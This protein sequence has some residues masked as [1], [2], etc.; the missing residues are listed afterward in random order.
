MDTSLPEEISALTQ[1]TEEQ[2]KRVISNLSTIKTIKD[3]EKILGPI[4][5]ELINAEVRDTVLTSS[6]KY[7]FDNIKVVF[8]FTNSYKR[9]YDFEGSRFNKVNIIGKVTAVDLD[10]TS[11]I[12]L[13]RR[14]ALG[15]VAAKDLENTYDFLV[16]IYNNLNVDMS[17]IHSS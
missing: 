13:L 3:A 12:N 17:Q 10:G 11:Q 5:N 15:Y 16:P 9:D 4:R 14:S 7:K 1:M 6:M 8:P 2:I